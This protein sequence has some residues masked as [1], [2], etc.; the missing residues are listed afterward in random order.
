MPL[1]IGGAQEQELDRGWQRTDHKG[2]GALGQIGMGERMEE[3]YIEGVV[4]QDGPES[5]V[6]TSAK[7]SGQMTALTKRQCSNSA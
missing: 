4:N 5:C 2:M 7:C 1:D 3:P 6:C